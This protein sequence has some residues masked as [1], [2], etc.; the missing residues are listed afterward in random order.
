[1]DYYI[2]KAQ[3]IEKMLNELRIMRNES[4]FPLRSIFNQA[5]DKLD[6]LISK[7]YDKSI[8]GKK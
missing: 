5:C 7:L 4:D 8:R 1:M 6:T 3:E 2:E